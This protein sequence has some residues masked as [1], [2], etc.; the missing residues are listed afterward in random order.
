MKSVLAFTPDEL[1]LV[2]P[3]GIGPTEVGKV[4]RVYDHR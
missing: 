1:T 4:K 3:G 2:D